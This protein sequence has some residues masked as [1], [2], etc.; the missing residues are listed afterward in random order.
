MFWTLN[1][2]DIIPKSFLF[3]TSLVFRISPRLNL[4]STDVTVWKKHFISFGDEKPLNMNHYD[5]K[6]IKT[7]PV[8]ISLLSLGKTTMIDVDKY[9]GP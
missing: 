4:Y 9:F 3:S 1:K 8:S 7:L 6:T 5:Y 2:L